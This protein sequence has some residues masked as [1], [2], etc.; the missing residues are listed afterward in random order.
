[1]DVILYF[2]ELST[3]ISFLQVVC[4][5]TD[6]AANMKKPWSLLGYLNNEEE[7]QGDN[8]YDEN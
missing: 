3:G 6:H 2:Y 7:D 1:M 8:D 5:M 4:T